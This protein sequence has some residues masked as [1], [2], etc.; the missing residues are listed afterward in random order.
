MITVLV[1]MPPVS[2]SG[3]VRLLKGTRTDS[4]QHTGTGE[5]CD[6]EGRWDFCV[7]ADGH[8][9]ITRTEEETG[10]VISRWCQNVLSLQ[11]H[12]LDAGGGVVK[13]YPLGSRTGTDRKHKNE[14][15]CITHKQMF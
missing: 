14:N 9:L 5:I 7:S 13:Y 3:W 2:D 6:I 4:I 15:T 10:E 1:V 12:S 11:F 8:A